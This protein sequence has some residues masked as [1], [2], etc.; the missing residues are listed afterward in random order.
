VATEAGGV[1]ATTARGRTG[2]ATSTIALEGEAFE[3]TGADATVGVAAW[4]PWTGVAVGA[5]TDEVEERDAKRPEAE[6]RYS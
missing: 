6:R 5:T 2:P 1:E 3:V 4:A